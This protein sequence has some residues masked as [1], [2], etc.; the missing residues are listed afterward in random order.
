MIAAS[1]RVLPGRIAIN[2]GEV[3]ALLSLASLT[4]EPLLGSAAAAAFLATGALLMLSQPLHSL[5]SLLRWWP[6]LLLPGYCLLLPDPV[7]F[8]INDLDEQARIAYSLDTIRIGD[9]LL[10]VTDAYRI[11]YMSL[12][13]ADQSLHTHI[14]PRYMSE[15]D[16]K[17]GSIAMSAYDWGSGRKFDPAAKFMATSHK[18]HRRAWQS[19]GSWAISKR[20]WLGSVSITSASNCLRMPAPW[21]WP[22]STT[23]R[24]A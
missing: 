12:S 17:R 8:S 4:L 23:P 24:P 13:N 2:V 9:A 14:I 1:A 7:A 11:N 15:P 3:L 5:S 16:D 20:R 19:R 10:A 6:L 18:D 22:I 21:L